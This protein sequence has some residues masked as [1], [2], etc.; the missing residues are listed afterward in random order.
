MAIDRWRIGRS[1][2]RGVPKQQTT[3]LTAIMGATIATL[4]QMN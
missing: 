3:I 4:A 2:P 1:Q